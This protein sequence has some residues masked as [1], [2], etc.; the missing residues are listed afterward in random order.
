MKKTD[1]DLLV[2]K[3]HVS[4][5]E[6][7]LTYWRKRAGVEPPDKDVVERAIAT[8]SILFEIL[9][10]AEDR[11]C[12]ACHASGAVVNHAPECPVSLLARLR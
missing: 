3:T 6:E 9:G 8:T 10:D 4:E 12:V 7:A 1:A 5:L 2:A 11:T